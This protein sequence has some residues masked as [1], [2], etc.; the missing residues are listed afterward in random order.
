MP[1]SQRGQRVAEGLRRSAENRKCPEC[2]RS[3]ALTSRYEPGRKGY[4]CRWAYDSK[5]RLCA[6]PGVWRAI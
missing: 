2:G 1:Y 4:V 5:G 6:W 3:A